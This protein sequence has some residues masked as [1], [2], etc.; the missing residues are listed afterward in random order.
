MLTALSR[1]VRSGATCQTQDKT[2]GYE[3]T[4]GSRGH[5]GVYALVCQE[6]VVVPR[7]PICAEAAS[8]SAGNTEVYTHPSMYPS[9]T[10][11]VP[12]S[13][14]SVRSMFSGSVIGACSPPTPKNPD[15]GL[16][17]GSH[18]ACG[19]GSLSH[20]CPYFGERHPIRP[21]LVRLHCSAAPAPPQ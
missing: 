1:A 21:D 4:L 17:P 20:V 8:R 9:G 14:A 18:A 16:H 5:T 7:V 12:L 6:S 10:V 13:P 11:H 2:P 19:K 3:P 15:D